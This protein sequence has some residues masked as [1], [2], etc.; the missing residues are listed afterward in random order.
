MEFNTQIQIERGL[1][2]KILRNL[3]NK[4]L[5]VFSPTSLELVP[6]YKIGHA[7]RLDRNDL[8]INLEAI[9]KFIKTNSFSRVISLGSGQT[10]DIS[11]YISFKKNVEHI[12]IPAI[13][14]TNVSFTD[15]SCLKIS[16]KKETVQSKPPE[17][18]VIDY[19][20]MMRAKFKYH[21]YGLCD[22][23]SIYTALVDWD[24]SKKYN[25]ERVDHFSYNI[26]DTLTKTLEDHIQDL[27]K[28][29]S[30]SLDIILK[31]VMISGYI[32]N[33]YGSGR[34]ESGSEHIFAKALESK[35]DIFHA[36]SVGLGTLL[37]AK[38]QKR[39]YK[40][41][42]A[43]IQRL[44]LLDEAQQRGITKELVISCL[45][46]IK[47]RKNRF[48]ILNVRRISNKLATKITNQVFEDCGI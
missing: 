33:I 46:E 25:L 30:H 8:G 27:E 45:T 43:T 37:M 4:D 48:S 9:D 35:I 14:S 41:I 12:C 34:P 42:L 39:N 47:P 29:D 23:I 21:Y 32:T 20:L 40:T 3:T 6:D 36:I 19:D 28:Q 7:K 16:G 5:F 38:L 15:K 11:K 2:K 24:L 44:G 1:S 26:A 18:V 31:L 17:N 13:F 10:S 22:I